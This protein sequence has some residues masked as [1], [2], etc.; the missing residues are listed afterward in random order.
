MGGSI[1]VV[2]D[3]I[4]FFFEFIEKCFSVTDVTTFDLAKA[5]FNLP[6]QPF[7]F[8]RLI[9]LIF[10]HRHHNGCCPTFL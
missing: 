8:Q 5:Y 2:I 7:H 3:I 10:L 6:P 4:Q 1:K 9:F